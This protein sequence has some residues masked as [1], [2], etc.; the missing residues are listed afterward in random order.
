ML[1]NCCAEG[2]RC[3]GRWERRLP[4]VEPSVVRE[5]GP[6]SAAGEP[7]AIS[8]FRPALRSG[9][10]RLGPGS[11][12]GGPGE[13]GVADDGV[14]VPGRDARGVASVEVVVV[15]HSGA[16]GHRRVGDR[17][18]EDVVRERVVARG[19]QPGLC[20]RG[21]VERVVVDLR[22][23]TADRAE[24]HGQLGVVGDD[25]VAPDA[26]AA[27]L[28][29]EGEDPDVVVVQVV[30]LDDLV[31]GA[32]VGVDRVGVAAAGLSRWCR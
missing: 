9:S 27:E 4:V 14:L 24:L 19:H 30:V 8:Q 25:V 21:V 3:P 1:T 6:G 20:R 32:H 31:R 15:D 12:R 26:G 11:A 29:L 2:L 28:D 16:A 7:A 23:G 10:G 17:G 13:Q 18:V 22:G 5:G